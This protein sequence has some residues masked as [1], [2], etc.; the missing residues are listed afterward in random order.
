MAAIVNVPALF[1]VA[2]NEEL[3]NNDIVAEEQRRVAAR[4][5]PSGYHVAKGITHYGIYREDF[6]EA[7]R[8]ELEWLEERLKGEPRSYGFYGCIISRS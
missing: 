6:Q 1:V 3:S 2:E 8:V 7:V 4:G 5:V